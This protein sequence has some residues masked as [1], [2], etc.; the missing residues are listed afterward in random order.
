MGLRHTARSPERRKMVLS[1]RHTREEAHAMKPGATRLLLLVLLLLA[2]S[3]LAVVVL[4]CGKPS[5]VRSDDHWIFADG[6]IVLFDADGRVVDARVQA[7]L[8]NAKV[9][10]SCEGHEGVLWDATTGADG[11]FECRATGRTSWK[12]YG[13]GRKADYMAAAV[14]REVHVTVTRDG[15]AAKTLVLARGS[16]S[17]LTIVLEPTQAPLNK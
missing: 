10:F 17:N 5:C 4:I 13:D 11:S 12:E 2:V 7:P 14:P 9:T 3:V 6:A 1:L 8:A 16:L 15:Y